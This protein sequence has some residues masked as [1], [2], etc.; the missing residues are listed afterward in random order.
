MSD[1]INKILQCEDSWCKL[2]GYFNPYIDPFK[3]HLTSNM[4]VFDGKAYEKYPDYKFVYDKLWII[5][6]QGLMGG[7][8]EEIRGK[9][10]QL[11]KSQS[12]TKENPYNTGKNPNNT[13]KSPHNTGQSSY[14]TGKNPNNTGQSPHNTGVGGVSPLFIKPRWGHLSASSK[15]CFKVNNATELKKYSHFE[16]MIWSEFIDAKEGMTDYVMFNGKIVHQITYIYSEKQNGFT[17]DWKY[18]SSESKPPATI[19]EWVN[20]HMTNYTGIVNVQY[21]DTKIIEIGLRLARAGAYVL[22]TENGDL[23][24]NV[25]N[26]FDK[27]TWDFTLQNKLNFKPFYVFKCYTTLPIVY[28][29][30]QKVLDYLIKKHT[31]YPFYEYYFEPA[32][33]E[34]MVFLQFND[35]DFNRGM[36]TKEKIQMWFNSLQIIAYLLILSLIVV[37]FFQFKGKYIVI[38]CI[39]LLLSTRFLNPMMANY[40]LYKAQRQDIFGSGPNIIGPVEE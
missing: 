19:T 10:E 15:N 33:K 5:K 37:L 11:F 29:F 25:N 27:Q 2:M 12:G 4:P 3:Y 14:N 16:H 17:D 22:S 1:I 36:R 13:G 40:N 26:I 6:S 35:D 38:A 32:G 18:I 7:K 21:R 24:K 28:L 30:P 31:R 8:F 9:E 23:I 34:G 20:R 39:I